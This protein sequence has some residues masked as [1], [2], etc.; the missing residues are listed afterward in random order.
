MVHP[1]LL[2]TSATPGYAAGRSPAGRSGWGTLE[3]LRR[4]L[5]G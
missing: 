1:A 5:R 3:R 4:L 2:R